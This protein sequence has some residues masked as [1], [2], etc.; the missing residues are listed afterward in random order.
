MA[1]P[2]PGHLSGVGAPEPIPPTPTSRP[3]LQA[4]SV[5]LQAEG[6]NREATFPGR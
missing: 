2:V 5:P 3:S 6:E 1:A 4:V